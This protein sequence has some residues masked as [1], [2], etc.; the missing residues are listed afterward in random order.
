MQSVI[1]A[2]G[3]SAVPVSG[4]SL[5]EELYGLYSGVEDVAGR[6]DEIAEM[7]RGRISI[8]T[9]LGPGEGNLSGGLFH[10]N[11]TAAESRLT[12]TANQIGLI[13]QASND[14]KGRVEPRLAGMPAQPSV[15]ELNLIDSPLQSLE[16]V[17]DSILPEMR[18]ARDSGINVLV[19]CT[20]GM[21]RSTAVILGH[22]MDPQ[23]ENMPLLDAWRHV[24]SR[25]S[26][27]FPNVGFLVQL[28]RYEKKVRG[29]SSVPLDLVTNHPFTTLTIED[30]E[31]Y[32]RALRRNLQGGRRSSKR[33][34]NKRRKSKAT[35]RIR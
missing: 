10:G 30:P 19:N 35:R 13:I 12:V 32:I 24:K 3:S 29:T 4:Q 22:L 9:I 23:G 7:V 25:R 18:R 31:T 8:S 28:M 15:I 26:L 2:E 6:M 34:K 14:V 16:R 21:S 33:S 1:H 5:R 11:I 27:A 20:V 17:L